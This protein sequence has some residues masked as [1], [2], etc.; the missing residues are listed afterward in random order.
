MKKLI[1][2]LLANGIG[3]GLFAQSLDETK[4]DTI[5]A[6]MSIEEKAGQMTNMA[7]VTIADEKNGTVVLNMEKL[8]QAIQ[9][10]HVGSYQNVLNH[11]YSL[12][13][14]HRIVDTIQSVTLRLEKHKVPS[15][16]CI[17]AVHGTNYTKGSALFPHNLAMA[18]TRNPD[19]ATAGG[20]I[21]AMEMRASGIR[22]NF[23]PVLDVGRQPLWPRFAE[24]FGEDVYLV[25]TMGAATIKGYEGTDLKSTTSVAACMKHY[26]GYAVPASGKDRA[27][28]YISD[29]QLREYFLPPFQEAVQTGTR[30]LMVNSAEINGIPVHANRYLLTD[31]LRNELGFKGVVISDWEDVKKL[32][33]RHK[34]AESYKEAVYQSVTAGIDL[35]IVPVDYNFTQYLIQLVK[36]GRI[37]EQRIDRSVKRI[38]MLKKELGLFDVPF[39][40]PS[41]IVQFGKPEYRTTSL[42]AAREAITLLKNE[43]NV[44]PLA[45]NKKILV[46]G[47]TADSKTSLCGAWSYTWQG[48]DPAYFDVRDLTVL[49]AIREK[50]AGAAGEVKFATVKE[51]ESNTA[52]AKKADYIVV[53]AGEDSY[54]ETPGNIN[55]LELPDDQQ[56]LVALLAK[57]GKPV[58]MVLIEGR[59]RIVREIEP[60]CKGI[61]MA[62]WPGPQGGRAIA[63]ILFGDVNPSGKLPFTYPRNTGDIIAYDHK[64]LDEAVEKV[65]PYSYT[66]EFNPQW[67]FGFGLSYTSFAYSNLTLSTDTLRGNAVLKISVTVKNTGARAGKEAVELYSKDLFASIT[68]SVKRLRKFTKITLEPGASQQVMFELTAADVAFVNN[69]LKWITEKGEFEVMVA[70]LK[71]SFVYQ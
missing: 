37:S 16:Y 48:K 40:E 52:L 69:E 70:G 10:Y 20:R 44:L 1:L 41:A 5:I 54:A 22:Y 58:I 46:I 59:P 21:T 71:K 3:A 66:L 45:K 9:V 28:A 64:L 27:P 53:C 38:L 18:A 11:A 25:K 19:L 62:Y 26:L 61:V 36:E 60:L 12:D 34:T 67:Q 6:R 42:E 56:R 31:L 68:P 57:S 15:L 29:I 47:P 55:S 2:F 65:D 39:V 24:T 8:Q 63:D 17:D 32:Y 7:L 33:E 35:C 51:F 50:T 49:A 4:I 43:K 23:S 30:T 13:E 14:W